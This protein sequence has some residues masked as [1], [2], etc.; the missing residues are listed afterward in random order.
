M[1][2]RAGAV[3]E[4]VGVLGPSTLALTSVVSMQAGQ[5]V[6]KQ[7]FDVAGPL[8]MVALRFGFGAAVLLAV[9]RPRVV[10]HSDVLGLVLA[11][12]T[13]LAG[14]TTLIFLAA[15]R[16]PLGIAVT[17]QFLGPLAVAIVGSQRRLDL[18]WAALAALGV[19]LLVDRSAGP[20]LIE[21]VI[22]ALLSAACWA[23][24]I[25]G[26]AALGART[27]DAR[28]GGSAFALSIAWAALLT[29]PAGVADAGP[30]LVRLDVLA[31]GF[32]VAHL[33]TVVANTL[34]L[35]ALRRMPPRAF[36]VLMSLEPAVAA[37]AGM[38]FLGE[39]LGPYQW[40]AVGCV[41]IASTGAIRTHG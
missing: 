32:L 35:K 8:G 6:A 37:L 11:V 21:G 5:A 29:V 13:A 24:Y 19:I 1:P 17:L 12:G 7:F 18:V 9:W 40:L 20:M 41:V 2:S 28:S 33:S 4:P 38:A 22:L 31:G 15:A 26:N 30:A 36:G 27:G 23:A 34:E 16:I 10:L 3:A 14:T 25:V 39:H